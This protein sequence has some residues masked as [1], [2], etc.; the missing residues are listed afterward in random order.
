MSPAVLDCVVCGTGPWGSELWQ[1][2]VLH[3]TLPIPC[4][5]YHAHS[6]GYFERG[7]PGGPL[8]HQ[9]S[10]GKASGARSKLYFNSR[11]SLFLT[12]AFAKTTVT[13]LSPYI[14]EQTNFPGELYDYISCNKRMIILW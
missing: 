10:V 14:P 4:A 7:L 12:D 11:H 3:R 8:L 5:V 13:V 6:G 2:R 9:T 1:G